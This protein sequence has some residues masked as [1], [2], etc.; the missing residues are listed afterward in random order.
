MAGCYYKVI[1]EEA[2]EYCQVISFQKLAGDKSKKNLS[3]SEWPLVDEHGNKV[4]NVG[5]YLHLFKIQ[6]E[7]G[8]LK[9]VRSI[10][11]AISLNNII[12]QVSYEEL[13]RLLADD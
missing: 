6:R 2:E 7:T 10:N 12:K 8:K 9:F 11:E 3:A 1:I 13:Y 4:T 5:A